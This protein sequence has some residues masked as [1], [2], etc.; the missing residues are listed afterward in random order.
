MPMD[1]CCETGDTVMEWMS[2]R[3]GFPTDESASVGGLGGSVYQFVF[4]PVPEP[5]SAVLC[6]IALLGLLSFGRRR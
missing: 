4:F 1:T 6:F 5:S 3:S 2:T